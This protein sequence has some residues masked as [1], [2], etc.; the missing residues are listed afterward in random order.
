MALRGGL[1]L[2]LFP[3]QPADRHTNQTHHGS[4]LRHALG[5]STTGLTK[6]NVVRSPAFA[7]AGVAFI[8]VAHHQHH[9]VEELAGA[10]CRNA[11][12]MAFGVAIG[13]GSPVNGGGPDNA[14]FA[15][16]AQLALGS[17]EGGF[18]VVQVDAEV[19]DAAAVG[20]GG[21][22]EEGGVAG[23]VVAA[24]TVDAP[25]AGARC[26]VL[27]GG[28]F[29]VE[30]AGAE[31]IVAEAAGGAVAEVDV[32]DVVAKSFA[33]D[34]AGAGEAGEVGGDRLICPKGS[35]AIND[36]GCGVAGEAVIEVGAVIN[37]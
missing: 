4:R 17:V 13:S 26:A 25:G 28:G 8:I 24:G 7:V 14:A 3:Q 29:D 23:A 6:A 10:A 30:A 37:K 34:G 21:E 16:E 12:E 15:V 27:A 19:T 1:T 5:C 35:T 31:D 36:G 20:S 33:V 32:E 11:E 9:L 2:S 22:V 18:K